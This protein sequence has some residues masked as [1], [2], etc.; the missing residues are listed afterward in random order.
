M[1]FRS[2]LSAYTVA[3]GNKISPTYRGLQS[4]IPELTPRD[5]DLLNAVQGLSMTSKIAQWEFIRALRD[6]HARD[7]PG[8][9][10]ECGVWRGGNLCLAGLVRKEL[11]FDRT[12]WAYDTFAGMTAPTEFDNKPFDGVDTAQKFTDLERDGHNEWCYAAIKDVSDN[13]KR[14]VGSDTGLNLI[15]GPVQETLLDANNLP[16]K[17]AMLRLDTDFYDSTKAEME[18]LYPRLSTGGILII[19]DYGEWAGARKAVDEYFNDSRV[20]LQRVTQSVRMMIKL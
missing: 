10:V 19:D 16:E 13:F 18:I 17:I 12:I 11:G 6:L 14:V 1:S 2:T 9:L 4:E 3:L 5:T 15:E 20:W 7:V 8:D